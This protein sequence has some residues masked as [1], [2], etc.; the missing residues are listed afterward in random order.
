[1]GQRSIEVIGLARN[2]HLLVGAH[3][4]QGTHV[5]KTVGKFYEQCTYIVM[6]RVEHLLVVVYLA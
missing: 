2:L 5:M 3:A 1:M 6:Q 4:T